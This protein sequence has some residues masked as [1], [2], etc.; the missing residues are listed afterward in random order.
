MYR[1]FAALLALFLSFSVAR[2]GTTLETAFIRAYNE[3]VEDG[4]WVS[5]FGNNGLLNQDFCPG[6]TSIWPWPSPIAGTDLS[7]A[8][9][10]GIFRCTYNGGQLVTAPTGAVIIDTTGYKSNARPTGLTVDWFDKLAATI[11]AHYGV[12]FVI[13]WNTS[14]TDSN[15]QEA[16]ILSGA[17]DAG[18][19]GFSVGAAYSTYGARGSVFSVFFCPTYLQNPIV[20]MTSSN[21]VSTWSAFINKV[22]SGWIV[23]A[24]GSPGGGSEQTCTAL[25]KQYS[26]NSGVQCYG[27][28][29]AFTQLAN[30]NCNAVFSGSAAPSSLAG[31]FASLSAPIVSAEGTLFRPADVNGNVL[32]TTVINVN[33]A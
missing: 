13:N 10:N 25:L 33:I 14:F 26:T 9:Q 12:P 20:Y 3:R 32:A 16:A 11:S 21:S 6:S 4:T 5:Y 2:P 30:G 23:Y 19:G 17:F 24:Y 28:L 1:V 29:T 31:S 27:N 22:N 18:C 15:S 7:N 8:L